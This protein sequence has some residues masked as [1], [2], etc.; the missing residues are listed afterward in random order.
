MRR[1]LI[2]RGTGLGGRDRG[3]RRR[4]IRKGGLR[5]VSAE[6]VRALQAMKKKRAGT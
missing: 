6:R 2:W 4:G 1:R 3:S 5:M